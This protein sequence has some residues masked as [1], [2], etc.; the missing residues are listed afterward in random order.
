MIKDAIMGLL[1]LLASFIAAL[2]AHGLVRRLPE[3]VAPTPRGIWLADGMAQRLLEA[4]GP[5]GA[6]E[7]E[8]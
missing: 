8:R 6:G 3:R 5:K 2:Q 4:H 1:I 7:S